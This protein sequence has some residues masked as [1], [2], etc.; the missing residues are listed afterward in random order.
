MSLYLGHYSV[1]DFPALS[2]S[3][4][5]KALP[6]SSADCFFSCHCRC[7][8]DWLSGW[9]YS[10]SRDT[11]HALPSVLSFHYCHFVTSTTAYCRHGNTHFRSL[12]SAPGYL[13]I[14]AQISCGCGKGKR[15]GFKEQLIQLIFYTLLIILQD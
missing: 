3:K 13:Y 12:S 5:G 15:I 2:V 6:P 4:A 8:R 14:I 7:C 10:N 11:F 9:R 1:M